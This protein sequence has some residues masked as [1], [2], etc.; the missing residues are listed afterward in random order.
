MKPSLKE[1]LLVGA[2]IVVLLGIFFFSR[3]VGPVTQVPTTPS[4]QATAPAPAPSSVVP[5]AKPD[6]N[7]T[8]LGLK[9]PAGFSIETFAK[10]LSGARVMVF[11]PSGNMWVSRTS[12][13]IVSMLEIK[14]GKVASQNDVMHG[15]RN[16]HGL[17]FNPSEPNVLY[18]AEETKISKIL[19]G[20]EAAPKKIADLPDSGGDHITR[21]LGFGPD[22][23]LYVS[24]GSACNVCNNTDARR[25][26]VS[27][28]K[29]NGSDFKSFATGL[30][31][32]VFFIWDK[33]GRMWGTDMGRDNLGDNVP[34]DEINIIQEGK[35]YG[36]PICYDDNIHDTNFDKKQYFR[37]PC[38]DSV[39][40]QVKL[41]AHS[42]PLGLAFVP[43]KG[44]WPKDYQGD[45]I[46]AFHG[47]WNRSVATGYKLVKVNLDANGNYL[48]VEDFITGWAKGNSANTALG[49]PAGV[50][51][52]ADGALYV[53]DD[54][55]GVIYKITHS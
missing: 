25:A 39:K 35:N 41:Q 48:G 32:T 13:G 26:A 27:S 46:V 38:A 43:Q 54:K 8:G 3:K 2:G 31:N 36:W 45:L 7:T 14:D 23:R 50:L 15:L 44:N 17:A 12:K 1:S 28:M 11:D 55:D 5:S 6:L 16:P 51:M 30:R 40:P 52:G 42:A 10:N 4:D 37:D 29:P 9:L 33:M 18:V 53:S 47:S 19:L 22:G 20:T 34:P 21:T 49:R 24:I